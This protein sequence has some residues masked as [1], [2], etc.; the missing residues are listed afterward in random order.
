MET[1]TTHSTVIFLHPF[2]LRGMDGTAP[3]GSYQLSTE[4]EKLDTLTIESWRQTAVI[5]QVARAGITEYLT[6]D[7]DELRAARA[8]DGEAP[9]H[10]ATP[11]TE[12]SGRTRVLLRLR[13]QRP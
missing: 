5:L 12:R 1:R 10:I 2:Q 8:R 11:L 6:I 13:P 4:E 7:P 3:A 9:S